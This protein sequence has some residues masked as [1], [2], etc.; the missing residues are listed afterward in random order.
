MFCF[1]SISGDS[2]I[3]YGGVSNLEDYPQRFKYINIFPTSLGSSVAA[4][5]V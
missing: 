1:V 4:S 5:A 3:I 2:Y